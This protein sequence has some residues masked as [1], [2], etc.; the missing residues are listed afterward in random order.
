MRELLADDMRGS[1]SHYSHHI[2]QNERQRREETPSKQ[3]RQS[4]EKEVEK[5]ERE[6][7]FESTSQ[8]QQ[9]C[10]MAVASSPVN[11]SNDSNSGD[12]KKFD[13]EG[14]GESSRI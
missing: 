3:R 7:P 13:K 6:S 5:N 11:L 14:Q 8:Q 4:C 9:S 2:D 10:S 1:E 12:E